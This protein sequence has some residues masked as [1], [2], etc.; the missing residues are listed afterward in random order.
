MRPLEILLPILLAIYLLWRHPRPLAIRLLPSAAFLLMLV[1]IFVEGYRWQMVPLYILTTALTVSSLLKIRSASDWTPLASSL[2]VILLVVFVALPILLPIP[3]IPIPDGPYQVGTRT[4]ELTDTSHKE[5]YSG[6]DEPRRFQIQVWYPSKPSTTD[7]R[8][9]WMNHAEVF[10]RSISQYLELPPFFLDHLALVKLPAYK[11]SKI[12]SASDGFPVILFSHGWNG[13]NAQNTGQALQLASYGYVVVTVQHPYG[14]LVTVFDDGSIAKNNPA[15]LPKDAPDEEYDIAADKLANQWAGDLAYALDFMTEQNN[16]SSSPFH[17]K[18][19]LDRV[20]AYG[21]ST[22]GGAA[23]QFCGTDP[24]CKALLGQ[25]PFMRPVSTEVLESGV[26]QPAFFMFSQ[27]WADDKS[28][29]NNRQFK[30]FYANSN[31]AI[32]AIS[33]DGTT[34]YDFSDL[35]LLSPLAPLLGLKGP[36]NGKRV[37]TIVDDYLLS[38]FEMTLQGKVSDLFNFQNN[39][40][41]EIKNLQ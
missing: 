28:S 7:E 22:G 5:L 3:K 2:T 32:G 31:N 30:P 14:A 25:D 27:V 33:I 37:T 40:Y 20:G 6:K 19:G 26:T 18:L 11:N 17:K 12:E 36:I 24:R 15:A 1:H 29:L 23:I 35:P 9:H 4:Y 8:A 38:F 34:H 10:T 39:K 21:H 16:A 13:F 41:S